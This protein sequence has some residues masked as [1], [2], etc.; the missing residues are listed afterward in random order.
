[1]WAGLAALCTQPFPACGPTQRAHQWTPPAL[2]SRH[3]T[4]RCGS[5]HPWAGQDADSCLGLFTHRAHHTHTSSFKR[6]FHDPYFYLFIIIFLKKKP[7]PFII[8]QNTR[9]K[10]SDGAR[11]TPFV[12]QLFHT[13][14]RMHKTRVTPQRLGGWDSL[15]H[16]LC[17]RA[18]QFLFLKVRFN[19]CKYPWCSEP[20]GRG[21]SNWLDYF[22]FSSSASGLKW[23]SA[24][25]KET[26]GSLW[27]EIRVSRKEWLHPSLIKDPGEDFLLG[28]EAASSQELWKLLSYFLE[29]FRAGWES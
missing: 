7:S 2:P 14:Q 24:W 4:G 23:E 19:T 20:L 29:Q 13:Y 9:V 26:S 11:N 15:P 1:M 16:V 10:S 17:Q 21:C 22:F 25:F 27:G 6:N 8:N 5:S 12:A 28:K 18:W 3:P